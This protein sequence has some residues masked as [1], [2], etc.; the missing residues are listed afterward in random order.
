VLGYLTGLSDS[1][2]D[3][4]AADLFVGTSAGAI[5][6]AQVTSTVSIRELYERQVNPSTQ[7]TDRFVPFDMEAFA[8]TLQQQLVQNDPIKTRRESG[9]MA[10]RASTVSEAERRKIISNQLLSHTWPMKH[11][12]ITAVD[13]ETGDMR[14]F[15]NESGVDLVDALAAS[16]A[17]PGVWPPATING[18]RYID[19]GVRTMENADLAV[20]Y[21]CVLILQA[22]P[23]PGVDTLAAEIATL[24]KHGSTVYATKPDEKSRMA[25]GP[26][27]LDPEVLRA[28]ALAA[29]DQG[30]EEAPAVA[31]LW[32]H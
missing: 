20:G 30:R 15:D 5:V 31:R 2:I 22:M 27:P 13:A 19:G 17:I 7:T 29:Y 26:N 24:R 3:I 11:I 10:L 28:T 14:V 16:T 8:K 6:A 21:D 25:I 18:R 4:L 1:G 32:S 12:A 23:V 9:A